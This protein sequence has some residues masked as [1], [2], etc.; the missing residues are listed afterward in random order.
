MLGGKQL[1]DLF[2]PAAGAHYAFEPED[3]VR[4]GF[5]I[6]AFL[7]NRRERFVSFSGA[8]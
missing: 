6:R 1:A 2:E 3:I 7:S 5:D 4:L 8:V